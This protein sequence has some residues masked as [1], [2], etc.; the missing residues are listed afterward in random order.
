LDL[1]V[2]VGSIA[3]FTLRSGWQICLAARQMLG[4]SYSMLNLKK[5]ETS[6]EREDVREGKAKGK[7]SRKEVLLQELW[8]GFK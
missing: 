3:R 4:L 1:G 6:N 8:I 2:L 7:S 5:W